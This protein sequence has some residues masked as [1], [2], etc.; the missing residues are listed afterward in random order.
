MISHE[1]YINPR[2]DWDLIESARIDPER[3]MQAI[4]HIRATLA[5]DILSV[6]VFL[7]SSDEYPDPR[8]GIREPT[9]EEKLHTSL[10]L[11]NALQKL[12]DETRA[13]LAICKA[14]R[15]IY[16]E[17]VHMLLDRIR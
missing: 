11:Y 15:D 9:V 7:D 10:R 6:K 13:A 3:R 8:M 5:L 2:L 14:E 16:K 12:L 17:Q 1:H 4:R